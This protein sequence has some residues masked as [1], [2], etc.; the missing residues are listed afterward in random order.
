MIRRLGINDTAV[1]RE[2]RLEALRTC[3]QAFG[4][5]FEEEQRLTAADFSRRV[6][7]EPPDA[8]FGAFLDDASPVGIA[9]FVV[10][11]HIKERHKGTLFSMYVRPAARG[12][13]VGMALLRSVIEHARNVSG[14]EILQL[15]VTVGNEAACA[16]YDRA[17]F[18]PYG[19]EPRALRL[20][21]G[22]Y[23]DEELRSLDLAAAPITS[24]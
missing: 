1:F 24:V 5:S 19:I 11:K 21:P 10:G 15:T 4:S 17:G 20:A 14:V 18:V 2:I 13:G 6:A 8:I 22:D 7:P 16:L 9:G 12:R 3:P 23:L